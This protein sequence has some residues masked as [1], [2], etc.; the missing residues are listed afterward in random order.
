ML[1]QKKFTF[2]G[3][4][5]KK[6]YAQSILIYLA[7]P[8]ISLFTVFLVFQI[9]ILDLGKPIFSYDG[10]SLFILLL[11]K[12]IISQ[13]WFFFN[14]AVGLPHIDGIFYFHDFP[15]QAS[16]FNFLVFKLISYF[17]QNPL[18]ILNIFFI[19]SFSLISFTSFI[20]L[21]SLKTGNLSAILVS[22]L[23]AFMP[24]HFIKGVNHIFLS[25]YMVI[26]L[27]FMVSMWIF[28]KKISLITLDKDGKFYLKP[29]QY[30]TYGALIIIFMS[31]NDIYYAFYG[32]I[33][34]IISWFI[35]ALQSGK[36]L[37]KNL[38]NLVALA[39]L[40]L[41]VILII[42]FPSII[43]WQKH[44]Y[45][46]L[47]D[48]II[49]DSE[50]FGLKIVNFFLPVTNHYI[51]FFRDISFAFIDA[52][53][54][55]ERVAQ[56]L[57]LGVS[58]CL[59]F[60]LLWPLLKMSN[61]SELL[62]KIIQ[63]FSLTK[64]D[65]EIVNRLSSMSLLAILFSTTGGLVMFI[66]MIFPSIRSHARFSILIAF[67]ALVLL[68]LFFDKIVESK[69]FQKKILAKILVIFI[70]ILM[71]FDQ[72]GNHKINEDKIVKNIQKFAIDKKFIQNIEQD[73]AKDAAI[74]NLP[75]AEFP[76]ARNYQNLLGYIHS[77][78]LRWSYPAMSGRESNKWQKKVIKLPFAEL[79]AEIKNAGFQGIL[80]NIPNYTAD[81]GADKMQEML[82]KF[83]KGAAK[84]SDNSQWV[85]YDIQ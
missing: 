63:K 58:F 66:A 84:F 47:S 77:E 10:D 48:R 55:G 11:I 5:D 12:T 46:N 65:Q 22:V 70:T 15:L 45:N 33:I 2:L 27:I 38:F 80:I 36:F 24:Y 54:G 52:V 79:I 83:S 9:N 43:F 62:N 32:S 8:L 82:R 56:S 57:G 61:K 85:F 73:F 69:I 26:P 6:T 13:G 19:A 72:S 1:N 64:R 17:T 35:S 41:L 53:G 40:Q 59:I 74:F 49:S 81:H 68:S 28:E 39:F 60:L 16:S 25:N 14:P 3:C 78:N 76:V 20:A 23:Y 37:N 31:V 4:F 7:A 75:F 21:K 51:E 18:L 30:F 34:F 44:G 50:F 71:I 67:F 29:N 42:Y